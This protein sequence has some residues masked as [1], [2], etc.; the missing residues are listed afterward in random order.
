MPGKFSSIIY[1]ILKIIFG[2]QFFVLRGNVIATCSQLSTFNGTP[3]SISNMGD[4][5]NDLENK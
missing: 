4:A 2:V 1:V 3:K 5:E